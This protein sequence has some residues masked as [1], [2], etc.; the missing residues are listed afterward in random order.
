MMIAIPM[1]AVAAS[2]PG[3]QQ[4]E[5]EAE[6]QLEAGIHRELVLGDL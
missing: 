3:W 6:R 4:P 2:L 1:M 5:A